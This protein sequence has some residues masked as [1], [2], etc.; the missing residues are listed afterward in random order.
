V[1]K[2]GWLW[3]PRQQVDGKS[4]RTLS[5]NGNSDWPLER[6]LFGTTSSP[7]LFNIRTLSTQ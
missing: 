5:D 4:K 1:I 7:Y 2:E 6:D 3:I